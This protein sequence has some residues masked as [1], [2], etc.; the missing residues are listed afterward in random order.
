MS[1][2][3][4]LEIPLY[5]YAAFSIT[6]HLLF[7]FPFLVFVLYKVVKDVF[8]TVFRK[9]TSRFSLIPFFSKTNP[10][11]FL[12]ETFGYFEAYFISFDMSILF[13]AC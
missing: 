8:F 1:F 5:F 6:Y 9:A 11:L 13:L 7:I 4:C 10:I 12:L 3:K 2:L